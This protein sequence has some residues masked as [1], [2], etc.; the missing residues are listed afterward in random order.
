[1]SQ[2]LIL[3]VVSVWRMM[4]PPLISTSAPITSVIC[5]TTL[6]LILTLILQMRSSILTI[7]MILTRFRVSICLYL[8]VVIVML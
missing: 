4:I 1:M 8:I 7:I 3:T 6:G 5:G 2:I